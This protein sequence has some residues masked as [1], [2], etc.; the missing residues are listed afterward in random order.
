MAW[1]SSVEV[2]RHRDRLGQSRLLALAKDADGPAEGRLVDRDDVVATD[3]G[4]MVETSGYTAARSRSWSR[5][6]YSPQASVDTRDVRQAPPATSVCGVYSTM[7]CA[8]IRRYESG[9][10]RGGAHLQRRAAAYAVAP[11][12]QLPGEAGA[13]GAG[14]FDPEASA[15]SGPM[16]QSR[17]TVVARRCLLLTQW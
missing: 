2:E 8:L 4:P 10:D 1:C 5:F 9:S 12:P 11:E 7:V 15:G 3:H 13:G 16:A 14:P 17:K 6:R